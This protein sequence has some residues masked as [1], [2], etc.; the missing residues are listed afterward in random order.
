[1][2]EENIC[3]YGADY[4]ILSNNMTTD[5]NLVKKLKLLGFEDNEARVYLAALELGPATM[6]AIHQKSFIKRTTCYQI[7]ENFIE[8]GIGAKTEEPKH[9]IYSVANPQNLVASLEHK[10]NLFRESLPQFEALVSKSRAKPEILLYKGL[11]GVR[12][13]YYQGLEGPE[14]GERLVLGTPKIW[15]D[16]AEENDAYIVERLKRNICLRMI[17]PDEPANYSMLQ[18]DAKE[19]RK[20]RFLP[21]KYF[22]PPI[23][24]HIYPQKIAYIAHSESEPFA[25]VIS[26]PAIALAERQKFEILWQVAEG[27]RE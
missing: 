4:V 15:L 8:R 23:E 13:V 25:T 26:N 3:C 2:E 20:T 1:M 24:T 9:T 27:R 7:F 21:K 12:Q 19:L 14:G 17:F 6:W 11:E 5:W 10:K 18:N 16:N 22:S